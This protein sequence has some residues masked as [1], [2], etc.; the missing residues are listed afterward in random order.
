MVDTSAKIDYRSYFFKKKGMAGYREHDLIEDI[1][2]GR[3]IRFHGVS[4]EY[5]TSLEK[6]CTLLQQNKLEEFWEH[7]RCAYII[8]Q[9]IEDACLKT[10]REL[11]NGLPVG[12]A[13]DYDMQAVV[14]RLKHQHLETGFNLA[15]W[16]RYVHTTVYREIRKQVA[17]IPNKKHCGTCKHLSKS[18][19][20]ICMRQGEIREHPEQTLCPKYQ[21]K[22]S[23][24]ELPETKTCLTCELLSRKAY[25][26]YHHA[27]K[28]NKTDT[29]CENY[30][31]EIAVDFIPLHNVPTNSSGIEHPQYLDRLLY[32][33]SLTNE[34]S[35]DNPEAQLVPQ[36][37]LMRIQD[38]LQTRIESASGGSKKREMY[39]RQ[40]HLFTLLLG[41]LY[42]DIS[43][44]D[45]V[46]SLAQEY[47]LKEW[48][49]KRDI[50]DVR[51]FLKN[52][53][54]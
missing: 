5:Y 37:E 23:L 29:V 24:L 27:E 38:E 9:I 17:Y 10:L 19:S 52:V 46:K 36:D 8:L 13:V 49:V 51:E 43:E 45:A 33:I 3:G 42:E 32:E 20:H 14:D 40:Y 53:L 11:Y 28:R 35:L 18:S 54:E 25:F 34:R 48:T 31:Q 41:K 39:E 12:D 2:E 21:L 50:K 47:H 30:S 26:C 22:T 44:D 4:C 15:V 6:I 7:G 16:H 1:C